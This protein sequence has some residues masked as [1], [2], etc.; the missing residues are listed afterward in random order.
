M[1]KGQVLLNHVFFVTLAITRTFFD[2]HHSV[3]KMLEFK[4]NF[5]VKRFDLIGSLNDLFKNVKQVID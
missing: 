3:K 5:V 2:Y 4:L 1:Q